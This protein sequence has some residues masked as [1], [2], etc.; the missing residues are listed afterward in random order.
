VIIVGTFNFEFNW[1]IRQCRVELQ[2]DEVSDTRDDDTCP[3]ELR[4]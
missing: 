4:E 1:G 2:N 3:A